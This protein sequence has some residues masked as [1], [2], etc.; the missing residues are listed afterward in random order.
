MKELLLI[1]S[2]AITSYWIIRYKRERHIDLKLV[3]MF[4]SG[5]TSILII[6]YFGQLEKEVFPYL[7]HFW[8][9]VS[10]IFSVVAVIFFITLLK[11][12][13]SM[14]TYH[15]IMNIGFIALYASIGGGCILIF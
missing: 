4:F 15:R 7:F 2:I 1:T 6:T 10:L 13:N 11:G 8:I 9:G 5:I 12:Y 14:S 3:S